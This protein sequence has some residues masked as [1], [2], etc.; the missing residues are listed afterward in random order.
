[1]PPGAPARPP[2]PRGPEP[3]AP[4]E[5]LDARGFLLCAQS[6]SGGASLRP[7]G[8]QAV[9]RGAPALL[10]HAPPNWAQTPMDSACAQASAGGAQA[11]LG[12]GCSWQDWRA[13]ENN[14]HVAR[15]DRCTDGVHLRVRLQRLA[16][17]WRWA[18][19]GW[20][21]V[22]GGW[23]ALAGQNFRVAGRMAWTERPHRSEVQVT[24]DMVAEMPCVTHRA[25]YSVCHRFRSGLLT[26]SEPD[27]ESPMDTATTVFMRDLEQRFQIATNLPHRAH[28]K[29]YYCQ[30]RE[31][32][33]LTLGYNP[34]GA[35]ESMNADGQADQ[36][37]AIAA[38]SP[39]YYE[40]NEHDV[41]DCQWK[42]NTGLRRLLTP[43]VGSLS[44]IRQRVVKTNLAFHR[45]AKKSDIDI[46]RAIDQS[47]PFLGEILNRVRPR[48]VLLT[49]PNASLFTT[50]FA[51]NVAVIAPEERDPGVKQV[52]FSAQ[53]AVLRATG[54]PVTVVQVAHASQF[55]WTYDR[56]HIP[57]RIRALGEWD[58]T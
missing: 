55:G 42:E 14:L 43:L 45:S 8:A 40:G 56:H 44:A 39:S 9:A 17:E 51:S 33:I 50:R 4:S 22:A 19:C 32:P 15:N 23:H 20:M 53:S 37:G 57:A 1:M 11:V 30:I 27:V 31:A 36:H 5:Q 21:S 52:V 54:E 6:V 25:R 10:R 16:R 7:G 2:Q 48:L 58:D 49:G 24:R 34:G 26:P 47:A 3:R 12:R 13:T 41:L 46:E 38:A 28:Y 35:P 29:I 18:A